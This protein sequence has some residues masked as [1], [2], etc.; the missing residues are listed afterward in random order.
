[1]P[2]KCCLIKSCKLNSTHNIF[3]IPDE[4]VAGPEVR[5]KWLEVIDQ[6]RIHLLRTPRNIKSVYG[7]CSAHFSSEC[8][9]PASQNKDSKGRYLKRPNLYPNAIPTINIGNSTSFKEVDPLEVNPL[10]SLVLEP[11]CTLDYEDHDYFIEEKPN[12]DELKV[13]TLINPTQT[14]EV[15][16]LENVSK[17][18]MY[19][20]KEIE[21]KNDNSFENV[22][23]HS[24]DINI[25]TNIKDEKHESMMID[26]SM[27]YK[28]EY[29]E[30]TFSQARNI[31]QHI[32]TVHEGCKD[33][34]CGDCQQSFSTKQ[35]LERH[36]KALGHNIESMI[37]TK[38]EEIADM[39]KSDSTT[40][41]NVK[42]ENPWD[43]E[44]FYEFRYYNCPSCS[45][46]YTFLQDFVNHAYDAHPESINYLRK[47]SDESVYDRFVPPWTYEFERPKKIKDNN[48]FEVG[49]NLETSEFENTEEIAQN[50]EKE[51]KK[52]ASHMCALCGKT[53]MDGWAL[54]SHIKG[55]HEGKIKCDIC[56]KSVSYY[57][58]LKKHIYSQHKDLIAE[59]ECGICGNSFSE[60]ERLTE[61][62]SLVHEI[63]QGPGG[64]HVCEV[65][66]KTLINATSLKVHISSVHREYNEYMCETCAKSFRTK[67]LLRNHITLV[68]ESDKIHNC[69]LCEEK[70]HDA[71]K[72]HAHLRESHSKCHICGKEYGKGKNEGYKILRVHIEQVHEGKKNHFCELCGQGFYGFTD[73][74]RHRKRHDNPNFGKRAKSGAKQ[75]T[76]DICGKS[77]PLS[78]DLTDHIETVHEGKRKQKCELCGKLLK[79]GCLKRHIRQVHEGKSDNVCETCGKSFFAETDMRRHIDSVHLKK[80]NVWKRKNKPKK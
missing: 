32:L 64:D 58:T 3:K 9:I 53:F 25:I 60:K 36:C 28:C 72:L 77:F 51:S 30:K 79:Y 68:H 40:S 1:M 17:Q 78:K 67:E 33:F 41:N 20:K 46:R 74:K 69:D 26:S 11:E 42:V 29:C 57:G 8:F 27:Y 63:D 54:K 13:E 62:F 22:M 50:N 80:P 70:F 66:G 49:A 12:I 65:C 59:H 15:S 6:D 73:M 4:H 19:D 38:S 21:L 55:F 24:D 10:A 18:E 2:R 16:S 75:T 44:S 14:S 52:E 39:Y 47:I 31:K 43:V 5:Q 45:N 56:G 71:Q 7:I 23:D 76:C 35:V 48:E 34:K 37:H 61:H